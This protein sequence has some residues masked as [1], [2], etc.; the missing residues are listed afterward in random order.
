VLTAGDGYEALEIL[1]KRAAPPDLIVSDVLMPQGSGP[2][3]LSKLPEAG[4]V[5]K[6][7]FTSGYTAR[8]V[9]ERPQLYLSLPFLAE[10][11]VVTDLLRKVR[12]VL[13]RP[14]VT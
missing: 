14:V 1:G 10:P 9:V 6:L 3:L 13:D 2:Q 7:L 12:E 11:R 4:P 5:P 8:D